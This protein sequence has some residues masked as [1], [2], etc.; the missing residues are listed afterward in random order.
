MGDF[1]LVF[2]KCRLSLIPY[3]LIHLKNDIT[4]LNVVGSKYNNIWVRV[5]GKVFGRDRLSFRTLSL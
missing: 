5:H 1:E 3:T 4:K 2:C